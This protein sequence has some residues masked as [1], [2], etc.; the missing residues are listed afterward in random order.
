MKEEIANN[1]QEIK[2]LIKNSK[3][4]KQSCKNSHESREPSIWDEE[5]ADEKTKER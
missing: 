2:S 5:E 1:N 4:E 3:T